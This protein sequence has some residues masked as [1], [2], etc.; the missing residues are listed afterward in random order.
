ML[1]TIRWVFVKE[2]EGL[3]TWL[4]DTL[5]WLINWVLDYWCY[6]LNRSVQAMAS[7]SKQQR[8][9]VL[10]LNY[11]V[12]DLSGTKELEQKHNLYT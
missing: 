11:A 5:G 7:T 12:D 10:K 2:V 6:G 1:Y 8:I 4:D 9:T 3:N